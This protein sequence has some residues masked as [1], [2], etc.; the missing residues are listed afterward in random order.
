[1]CLVVVIKFLVRTHNKTI[2]KWEKL[3]FNLT[4]F[5]VDYENI[6]FIHKMQ[7]PMCPNTFWLYIR[8]KVKNISSSALSSPPSSLSPVALLCPSS[9]TWNNELCKSLLYNFILEI[10]GTNKG[11]L[12]YDLVRSKSDTSLSL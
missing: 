4:E 2:T 3:C 5:E 12:V 7:K 8:I 11:T 9:Q 10:F 6:N 1:M